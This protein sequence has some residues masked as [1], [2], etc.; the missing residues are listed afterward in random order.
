[1]CKVV[2]MEFIGKGN[3]IGNIYDTII[4][5]DDNNG[6]VKCN[7]ISKNKLNYLDYN[8]VGNFRSSLDSIDSDYDKALAVIDYFTDYN[9][10]S[11]IYDNVKVIGLNGRFIKAGN[12]DRQLLVKLNEFNEIIY[13][14]IF[15]KYV[16]SLYKYIYDLINNNNNIDA[17]NFVRSDCCN[18]Y[19]MSDNS[20]NILE[21]RYVG[22]IPDYIIRII[23][24]VL[25]NSKSISFNYDFV[26]NVELD[27]VDLYFDNIEDFNTVLPYVLDNLSIKQNN[28]KEDAKQL[29]FL[30]D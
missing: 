9:E 19:I 16:L 26:Y 11:Y 6:V 4:L 24:D 12:G 30:R 10:I 25:S 28:I 20:V 13:N 7:A 1:M 2:L 17:I 15:N 21:V 18:E 29:V 27:N 22:K 14:K 3:L 8:V 23:N 5:E